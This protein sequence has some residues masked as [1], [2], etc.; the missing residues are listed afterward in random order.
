MTILETNKYVAENAY[1]QYLQNTINQN[2][3]WEI[4][5]QL[6]V[7]PVSEFW[8]V[9]IEPDSTWN[10]EEVFYHRK[11]WTSIFTYDVNRVNAKTHMDWSLVVLN[12]SAWIYNFKEKPNDNIFFHYKTSDT[13]LLIFGWVIVD[14]LWVRHDIDNFNTS[15]LS[16]TNNATNYIYI[17]TLDDWITYEPLSTITNSNDLFIIKEITKDWVWNITDIKEGRQSWRWISTNWWIWPAGRW[18]TSITLHSTNWAIKTYRVTFTDSTFFDYEIVDGIV[19]PLPE[20]T[21]INS[22]ID[23]NIDAN[24]VTIHE[25]ADVVTTLI[26]DI[27]D[28]LEAIWIPWQ[29]W[30]DWVNWTNWIDW[31]DGRWITS[32]TLLSTIGKI[33]TYRITFTDTTT[34]DYAVEDWAD[35]VWWD[36]FK[37]EN[38]SW[39]INYTTARTN[40][41]VYSKTE[42]DTLIPDVSWKQDTL[43][44]WTN[45]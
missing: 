39:L 35:G 22:I 15:D 21:I 43:V 11:A 10:R 6:S 36:M 17:A 9:I 8:W 16:L 37:S 25:L 5:I 34:F 24:S 27:K 3:T 32:I 4:E 41:D 44:S 12:N 1:R 42:V 14:W 33:K 31:D 18:I 19:I 38:L 30:L 7:A 40:L 13:N 26:N 23:R 45:I 20:Y 29:D 2:A 28:W